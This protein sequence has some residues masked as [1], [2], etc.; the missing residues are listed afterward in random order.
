MLEWVKGNVYTLVFDIISQQHNAEQQ[1]CFLL[2][3]CKMV[4]DLDWIRKHIYWQLS[5]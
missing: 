3:G 1:R 5:R 2:Q 4:D